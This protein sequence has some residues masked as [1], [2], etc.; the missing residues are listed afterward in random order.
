MFKYG[1]SLL[2]VLSLTSPVLAQESAEQLASESAEESEYRNSVEIFLGAAT[3][4]SSGATAF[5]LGLGYLREIS[6]DL[7]VA[8]VLEFADSDV[9][10]EALILVPFYVNLTGGLLLGMGPG[11][12]RLQEIGEDGEE[13]TTVLLAVRFSAAWEFEIG[14]R[15]IIAPE[16]NMDV[17]DG[18]GT[19][20]YGAAFGWAF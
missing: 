7:R 16:I 8:F 13:E 1:F 3:E 20:V 18:N 17:A 4:A 6:G 9:S 14:G 2:L 12:E 11:I 15:F 10:R 19:W 5:A